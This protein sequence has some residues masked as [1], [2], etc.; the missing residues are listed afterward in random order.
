MGWIELAI[1]AKKQRERDEGAVEKIEKTRPKGIGRHGYEPPSLYKL[2]RHINK[3]SMKIMSNAKY[4]YEFD[5]GY[6]DKNHFSTYHGSRFT[7][8]CIP[9]KHLLQG[10]RP[11]TN[12]CNYFEISVRNDRVFL[13]GIPPFDEELIRHETGIQIDPTSLS[14]ED[15]LMW[16]DHITPK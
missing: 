8:K 15:I 10:S 13:M 11:I 12:A 3:V 14:K 5:P 4:D 1:L 2:I 6:G 7:V 16:F 9:S